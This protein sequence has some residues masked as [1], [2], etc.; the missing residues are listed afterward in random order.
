[1]KSKLLIKVFLTK[2]FVAFRQLISDEVHFKLLF[3]V[4]F[5]CALDLDDM[6]SFAQVLQSVVDMG[7]EDYNELAER[8]LH[9]INNKLQT[10]STIRAYEK[11]F[12]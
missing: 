9:Y 3:R 6:D 10:E 5:G 7:C 1:M 12:G 11:M 2:F 4:I 8:T